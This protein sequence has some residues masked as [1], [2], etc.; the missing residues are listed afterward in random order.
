[1]TRVRYLTKSRFKLAA[2]CPRKLFYTGKLGYLDNSLED[3]FLAALAE[4][5]YQVGELA[6]LQFP[7]GVRVESL[8]HAVALQQ[9]AELLQQQDVTI[10]E[11][12][13]AVDTLFVR[14]DILRK[15]GNRIELIEVKAKSYSGAKDGD[16]RTRKGEL[17][18]D[19]LP[20]LQD[21][22]F[23]RYVVGQALPGCEV[24]AF[25]M[26]VNKEARATVDGL[27]QRFKA[28]R[29]DGR[30]RVHVAPDTTAASLGEPLLCM[31]SVDSQ[32]DQ[33]KA[34]KLAIAPATELPFSQAVAQFAQ[35]Y[36]QDSALPPIP[37]A[38][39]AQCQFKAEHFPP[40]SEPKSGFHECWSQAFGWQQS[41]FAVNSVLDIWNFRGKNALIDRG[42]LKASQVNEDD[43][44]FDGEE[45]GVQGMSNKHRQWYVCKPDW[46][47]GGDFYF[48]AQGFALAAS[49]WTFPLHFIDFETSA[50][51]IP[52]V[53][54]RRP[55]EMTAFQ[56]SHHV[57]EEDGS[58]RHAHQ[59][60]CAEP[61]VD[62]NATFVRSLMNALS[63]DGGTVFRWAAH[64]NTVL[65]KLREQLL[66]AN[67]HEPD[68][69]ELI[70]FIESITS[71]DVGSKE[72]VTGPRSMVDLC[73]L[74][75]RFYFHPN[76]KGSNSLKRVLPA[77]MMS[78]AFLRETY[79]RAW[80]GGEGVSLNFQEPVV[81]WQERGGQ[82]VDPYKLLPPVFDDVP[83]A[84]IE[85]AEEGLA[86]ELREGGAAMAAYGRLQFEDLPA[87]KR[88]AIKSAL[89]RY[90]ELDTLAMVM[91]V[92]A[93]RSWQTGA[94]H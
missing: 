64:E 87:D 63:A 35:A 81:W 89:F 32:V 7:E 67:P 16:F 6:C 20:Y 2:E 14:V 4:G 12:A 61:G 1:M 58:V 53:S 76:T 73:E 27:N 69:E 11:A 86:E 59:W 83:S 34:G 31:V 42:V 72:R 75:S 26:L 52:F 80:Y 77:L 50:V 29:V 17:K 46:P 88:V 8:E 66:D 39:C 23:Q 92:Q 21:V 41:D 38:A 25:L 45:P 79:S 15:R 57:M 51:A 28:V 56:F 3:S 24:K 13:L 30:L 54:G 33:I 22:A 65:N 60:L 36:A 40:P 44:S 48:D 71:R 93:W 47:G 68:A 91:A 18:S 5:G 37:Q 10:F 90:C 78:S 74:A 43:L 55:Y 9:T 62:P 70:A 84:E 82:V 94:E 85:A 19:F 49:Q